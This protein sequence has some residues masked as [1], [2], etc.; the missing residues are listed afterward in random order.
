MHSR[1]IPPLLPQWKI[2]VP[3]FWLVFLVWV[4][5]LVFVSSQP[6]KTGPDHPIL[7]VDKVLHFLFFAC[8]AI[9]F[10]AAIRA[11]FPVR[12]T[13]LFLLVIV[14]LGVL[15]LAD[16]IHQMFVT[17]RSGGD[18]FDWLADLLGI[19]GGLAFLRTFYAKRPREIA[20]PGTPAAN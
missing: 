17:G 18:P 11:T 14:G 20:P 8:G 5:F 15:G 1:Q 16:E 3:A 4:G 9:S 2:F 6:G 19:C 7:Y 13:T 10:G 12:W